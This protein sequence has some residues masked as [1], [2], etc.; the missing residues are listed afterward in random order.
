MNADFRP[1]V[2]KTMMAEASMLHNNR[3]DGDAVNRARHAK[4]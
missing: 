1:P 4:R 3:M 2:E